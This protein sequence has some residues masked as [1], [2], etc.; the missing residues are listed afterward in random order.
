E[1]KLLLREKS[2]CGV[3][4]AYGVHHPSAT[5]CPWRTSMKLW[6]ESIF[7][8]AAFTTPSTAVLDT[9]CDSGVARGRSAAERGPEAATSTSVDHRVMAG[10]GGTMGPRPQTTRIGWSGRQ[11]NEPGRCHEDTTRF[12][13][14]LV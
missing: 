5:T 6:N 11:K 12:A 7:L 13:T 8:S 3:W 2:M 9:P 10:L 4:A 14:R 1:V